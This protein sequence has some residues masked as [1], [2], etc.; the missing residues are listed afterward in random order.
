MQW[1]LAGRRPTDND[2]D[3]MY[4][5]INLYQ[6][7]FQQQRKI[8]SARTLLVILAVATIL[9]A[10]LLVYAE[11]T[12]GGLNNTT[13][14]LKVQYQQLNTQLGDMETSHASSALS[15]LETEIAR[16]QRTIAGR[17]ELLGK[18]DR[19][20]IKTSSGF[21][22]FFN[23]LALQTLPGLWITGIRLTHNGDTELRGTTLSPTL[24]PRYLQQMPDQSRFRSLQQGSVHLSRNDPKK[25]E[26][27]FVL[28]SKARGDPL[29]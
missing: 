29:Q 8:F 5:Q 18:L 24:V 23:A 14:S 25:P 12:L 6:P 3:V 4:Q 26:I 27:D 10:G 7:V 22:E 19:I 16:L 1:K 15:P 20:A 11:W 17:H 9:L 21:G 28:R 2:R 13:A